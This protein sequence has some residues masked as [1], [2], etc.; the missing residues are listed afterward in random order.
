MG[1]PLKFVKA[2]GETH[3]VRHIFYP[4]ERNLYAATIQ[5][6]WEP[7]LRGILTNRT[8]RLRVWCT[9]DE[10]AEYLF[11]RVNGEP[12]ECDDIDDLCNVRRGSALFA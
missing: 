3:E 4:T 1:M 2:D 9:N 8:V 5:S 6:V 7:N 12:A 11:F 10:R